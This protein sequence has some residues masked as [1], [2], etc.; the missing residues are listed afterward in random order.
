MG[1]I[2]LNPAPKRFTM[3]YSIFFANIRYTHLSRQVVLYC[4]PLLLGAI[5]TVFMWQKCIYS[6]RLIVSHPLNHCCL[7]Y[8]APP[9]RLAH[10]DLP[11]EIFSYNLDFF[12]CSYLFLPGHDNTPP[13]MTVFYFTVSHRGSISLT[14]CLPVVCSCLFFC[15]RGPNLSG[16]E[17]LTLHRKTKC[18]ILELQKIVCRSGCCHPKQDPVERGGKMF[19]VGDILIYGTHGICK[20]GSIGPLPMPGVGSSP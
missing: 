4:L 15:Q 12:F 13:M 11:T 10:T 3:P 7:I 18:G 2:H 14:G 17:N 19:Q 9:C 6:I 20:V 16:K 5:Y 1:I 8:P